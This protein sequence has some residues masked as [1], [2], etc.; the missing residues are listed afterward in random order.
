MEHEVKIE[1]AKLS[2]TA[3]KVLLLALTNWECSLEEAARRLLNEA[4]TAR[5]DQI[6]LRPA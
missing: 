4:A 5:E 2:E 3:A 6:E 1:I